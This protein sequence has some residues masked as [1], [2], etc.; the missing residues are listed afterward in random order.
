MKVDLHITVDIDPEAWG[1]EYGVDPTNVAQDVALHVTNTVDA[2]LNS[3]GL[4]TGGRR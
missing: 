2:H 4:L 3:L 1:E